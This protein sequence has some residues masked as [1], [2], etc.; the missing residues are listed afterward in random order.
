[1][2]ARTSTIVAGVSFVDYNRAGVPLCEIVSEPDMRSAE[3]AAEYVRA[4]RHACRATSASATA[5]WKRGRSAATPTCP[6]ARAARR[7]LGT[8]TESRT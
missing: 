3:E 2:R 7:K 4:I 1:M 6:S 8:K 5:T